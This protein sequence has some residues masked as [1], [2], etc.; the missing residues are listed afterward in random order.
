MVSLMPRCKKTLLYGALTVFLV[1]SMVYVLLPARLKLF[2]VI[3]DT[4]IAKVGPQGTLVNMTCP[5]CKSQLEEIVIYTS[6]HIDGGWRYAFY[7]RQE[8][9]FWVYDFAGGISYPTWYGPFSAYWKI[10]D[11]AAIS[12]AIISS[13]I[14]VLMVT[15]DKGRPK[16]SESHD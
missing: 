2:Y 12:I 3:D 6:Q 4:Y 5:L 9:I 1:L 8:D 16:N 10:T 14:L 7:C 11:T 13:V 15:R